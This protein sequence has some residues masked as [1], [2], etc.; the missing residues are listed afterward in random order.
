MKSNTNVIFLFLC[1]LQV[2]EIWNK[3][4]CK[5]SLLTICIQTTNV[6]VMCLDNFAVV[7]M[8]STDYGKALC[9]SKRPCVA[10]P[11]LNVMLWLFTLYT[12]AECCFIFLCATHE[13]DCGNTFSLARVC[14]SVYVC[15][16]VCLSCSCSNF[17]KRWPR[18]FIFGLWVHL[19]NINVH[20]VYQGHWVK[21]KVTGAKHVIYNRN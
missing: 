4:R 11:T 1:S 16:S 12:D 10:P 14:H 3:D 9:F 2:I 13:F 20:L 5:T 21:F 15:L 19:Q 17:W 18:N 7:D 8:C 6:T